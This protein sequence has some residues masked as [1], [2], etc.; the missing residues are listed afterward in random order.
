MSNEEMQVKVSDMQNKIAANEKVLA[1]LR[2]SLEVTVKIVDKLR[3][4]FHSHLED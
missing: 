4:V 3:A 2:E 1:D